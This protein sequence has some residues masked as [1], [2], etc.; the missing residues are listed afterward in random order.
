LDP[1]TASA[2]KRIANEV[3]KTVA[4]DLGNTPAV[5]RSSYIHPRILEHWNNGRFK[6]N[7]MAASRARKVVRLSKEETITLAYIGG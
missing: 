1:D 2:R 4:S 7:W 3:V 5:C 6:K